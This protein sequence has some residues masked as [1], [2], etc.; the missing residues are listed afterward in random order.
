M[1]RVQT[2]LSLA[3]GT[4][5][6]ATGCGYSTDR[7]FADDIQTVHVKML[8]SREF[9]RDLEFSLTEAL[10]K[11]IEMDTPYR[12][13]PLKTADSVFS[14]EILEVRNRTMGDEF[15]TQLPRETAS[16]IVLA[17]RWKDLR[18]GKILAEHPSFPWTVHYIPPVGESFE[19]GMVRGLDQ[20]AEAV[21]ERMET[22]W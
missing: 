6:F 16:T 1:T 7:P 2:I 18:T 17:F 13:A 11:R 3:L 5:L 15:E 21:V 22:P 12:V 4:A 10:V 19:V 20:M 14:G 8:H 9:R